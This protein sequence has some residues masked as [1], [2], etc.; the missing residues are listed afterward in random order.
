MTKR[1]L[2]LRWGPVLA[3]LLWL[4]A[5]GSRAPAQTAANSVLSGPTPPALAPSTP[6]N[7]YTLSGF[8][9]VDSYSGRLSVALPLHQIGGRG[10]AGYTMTLGVS[11]P[12]WTIENYAVVTQQGE[13]GDYL[14]AYNSAA[15]ADWWHPLRPLYSPGYV[16]KKRSFTALKYCA[17]AESSFYTRTMTHMVFLRPDGSEM[18]LYSVYSPGVIED[19]DCSFDHVLD[20]GT[21]FRSEDGSGT[22]FHYD[23]SA[24]TPALG[25]TSVFDHNEAS[26]GL[27]DVEDPGVCGTLY[28]PNGIRYL[29]DRARVVKII[30]RHGNLDSLTYDGMLLTSVTD[31]IGRVTT[32]SYTG[33]GGTCDVIEYPGV[34]GTPRQIKVHRGSHSERLRPAQTLFPELSDTNPYDVDVV[35]SVELPDNSQY[36]FYY[37]AYREVARVVLPTGGFVDYEHGHGMHEVDN[38]KAVFESGQVLTRLTGMVDNFTSS[39]PPYQPIIYRRLKQRT[40]YAQGG[41]TPTSVTDYETAEVPGTPTTLQGHPNNVNGYSTLASGPLTVTTTT[42]SGNVVTKHHFSAGTSPGD[43]SRS[44]PLPGSETDEVSAGENLMIAAGRSDDPGPLFPNVMEGVELKT[45][46]GDGAETLRTVEKAYTLGPLESAPPLVCQEV[47]TLGSQWRTTITEYSQDA[48]RNPVEVYELDY[49]VQP[50]ITTVGTGGSAYL[51]CPDV[52]S[53]SNSNYARW[54]HTDYVTDSAYRLQVTYTGTPPGTTTGGPAFLPRLPS[55]ITVYGTGDSVASD[56]KYTYDC[57]SG[58][59]GTCSLDTSQIPNPG[60]TY[61]PTH[62]TRGNVTQVERW[63]NTPSAGWLVAGTAPSYDLAGNVLQAKDANGN[64][65]SYSYLDSPGGGYGATGCA[66]GPTG[67][68]AFLTQITNAKV[69]KTNLEW[70]CNIGKPVTITDAN[71]AATT[72]AYEDLLD[73]L[74]LVNTAA[75]SSVQYSYPSTTTVVTNR[76]RNAAGDGQIQTDIMYDGFG[77]PV[78]SV[79][80]EDSTTI[81]SDTEYD[82]LG[83][84]WRVSNPYRSTASDWT[85]TT[86]DALGRV[87]QVE[88]PDGSVATTSYTG[89]VTTAADEAGKVRVLTHDALGRL[90]QVVEDPSVLNYSTAYAYD[91]LDN[92]TDVTQG[93]QGRSFSYNSL[94]R[95][96]SATN[97][98]SGTTTYTYDNNGNLASK[99]DARNVTTT[100]S[101]DEL[102][103]VTEKSYNDSNPTTPTVTLEYDTSVSISCSGDSAPLGRLT[104]STAGGV[105][106]AYRYDAAG[107]VIASQQTVDSTPYR[108]CYSYVPAGLASIK[109]PSDRE[110][111]TSYDTAGRM[112]AAGSYATDISYEAHGG[113]SSLH[114]GN[115]LTETRSYN[116]RLQPL[117]IATGSLLTLTY[118]YGSANN[119]NVMSQTISPLNAMQTYSYD[120]VNRLTYA[121][122]GTNWSQTFTNEQHP[123]DQ[124]GNMQVSAETGLGSSIQP[125]VFDPST[126]RITGP[127]TGWV[128]DNGV[129]G[130]GNLTGNPDNETFTYDAENRQKTASTL[131]GSAAYVYDGEGRRVKRTVG[132]L[133][134]VYVYDAMGRLAAEYGGS[135]TATGTQYL[136]ADHLGST[137]LVT[138]GTGGVVERRDYLPFGEKIPAPSGS[139]RLSVAGY[140]ADSGVTQSFTSKERDAE[141]GLD[142]FGARYYSGAQGRFTTTD[143]PLADQHAEDPQSWNLYSYVRN[144]PLRYTDPTGGACLDGRGAASCGNYIL[145]GLKAVGNIPSDVINTPNRLANLFLSPFTDFR[146]Q[147]AIQQTFAASSFD[148]QQGMEAAQIMMIAAPAAEAGASKLIETVGASAKTEAAAAAATRRSFNPFQGKTP[149][150]ASEMFETKGFDPR[151]PDPVGGKGGYLESGHRTVLPYRSRWYVQA[152]C[153]TAPRR[154]ES[155]EDLQLT[156]T[157]VPT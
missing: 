118:G 62:T 102:N 35:H 115:G 136:T 75:V 121:A 61:V 152:R 80:H 81:Q 112:T 137:R 55:Q 63:R 6:A 131:S 94:G 104:K 59:S 120:G 132:A 11:N 98:E 38:A 122:E 14:Y 108:F 40:E 150:Q 20:R 34:N 66:T 154:C 1:I 90:T 157:Q 135:N 119:G 68:H 82:A 72:A 50:G 7:V 8:D 133:A 65:T 51:D 45:E 100:M 67:S 70:D 148:Q 25:E 111:A 56:T 83:R 71:N 73:R 48:F 52:T 144:N 22:W 134:T 123:Y 141:T 64:S 128:Y 124:Y 49:G 3:C 147:D 99:T 88:Y 116:D 30:D 60:G 47:T 18:P 44:Q 43:S 107:R 84:V 101:Y 106:Q 29:I 2:N 140:T 149:D 97:P 24:C 146:F 10:E 5:A 54:T 27:T 145:G 77:R 46:I 93:A 41:T 95:L 109:Y 42:S 127:Q 15:S 125:L 151:G 17:T 87:T 39:I 155:T 36:S 89:N 143:K 105:E 86:Y 26:L 23:A 139:P 156:K 9:S 31:P 37:N 129:A 16:V 110:V 28:F 114:M 117:T 58:Q 126:N 130:P 78:Q 153:R 96:W 142:Y 12:A 53:E 21:V 32:V 76:D 57:G 85:T 4:L 103:R 13:G 19:S 113:V 74:T 138:N 91:V 79:L 92:L 33:C 69:Q